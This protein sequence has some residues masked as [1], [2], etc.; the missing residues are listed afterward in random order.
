MTVLPFAV[1]TSRAGAPGQ[2]RQRAR[3][4]IAASR[5]RRDITLEPAPGRDR[6]QAR[7]RHTPQVL[8][9]PL[10]NSVRRAC[11]CIPWLL[12]VLASV[13]TFA[14]TA[15]IPIPAG[16]DLAA[17][18]WREFEV[19]GKS[20]NRFVGHPDGS[21]EV[22]SSSSVSRL[23][24]PLEVKLDATPALGWRWRVDEPVPPTDLTQKGEDDTALTLFVGFP[25]DPDEASF[26]ERLTRPLVE[27]YAGEDAPGRVLAYVFGGAEP[28]GAWVESPHLGKA[29]AMRVLRPADSPTGEWFEERVDLVEDYRAAFGEDPPDPSQ[30]AI[31][32]DTD[33][34]GSTSRGFVK[35]LAFL[36]RDKAAAAAVT[37]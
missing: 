25:W 31:S 16:P 9:M 33:D 7:D 11:R 18:G 15:R 20:P 17:A 6:F 8:P 19:T 12:V 23:Y 24:R 26:T 36:G 30:L 34:T 13:G 3:R 10:R 1:D 28:R 22:I 32:A 5:S 2:A 35:D 37:D 29:G 21:I 14:A 4:G 27:A